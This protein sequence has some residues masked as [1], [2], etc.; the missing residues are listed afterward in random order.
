MGLIAP[1]VVH[2][3]CGRVA[4]LLEAAPP[5]L[6]WL[7][8]AERERLSSIGTERRRGQFLAARWQARLLLA[9]VAGGSAQRWSLGAPADAPPSVDGHPDAQLSVSHSA[10]RVAVAASGAAIGLDLE[11]PQRRR[12]IEGL[13]ALCC[14]PAERRMFDG[15][16]AAAR[17]ALFHELWTVKESWL[18]RRR[19]WIAPAR[20]AQL[21]ASVDANGEVR[22]WRLEQ[23][24]IAL[25]APAESIVH[26]QGE[27]PQ[28]LRRWQV[29]DL[30]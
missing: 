22:T 1:G 20:L 3:A 2:V 17:E 27:A 24:W 6:E 23:A 15:A 30:A 26:W 21:Q 13:V 18:K 7:S 29:A 8:G 4:A 19:E 5:A 28:R 25:C 11:C 9:Q 10:D 14:T 16:G 12:D